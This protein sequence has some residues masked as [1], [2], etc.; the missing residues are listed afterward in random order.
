MNK[1]LVGLLLSVG[2]IAANAQNVYEGNYLCNPNGQYPFITNFSNDTDGKL[3][4]AYK[5]IGYKG[6]TSYTMTHQ[7]GWNTVLFNNNSNEALLTFN[8]EY[9]N[10]MKL[11]ISA[12]FTFKEFGKG[13]SYEAYCVR[14]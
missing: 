2:C 5:F 1:L 8:T 9:D 7:L 4:L 12:G 6:I 13:K 10:N 14:M 11:V 3:K